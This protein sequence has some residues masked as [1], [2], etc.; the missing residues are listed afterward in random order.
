MIATREKMV[1]THRHIQHRIRE[2]AV[3]VDD[4][5]GAIEKTLLRLG[6]P[7]IHE[8]SMLIKLSPLIVE[9]MR[10]LVANDLSDCAIV[11]VLG[12]Q[13]GQELTLQNASG[14]LYA[15]Q[16]RKAVSTRLCATSSMPNTHVYYSQW[17]NKMH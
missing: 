6:F 5:F 1:V 10:D 8:V 9:S 12:T 16:R 2:I 14:E 15:N 3:L 13:G 11:Q 7:P 17:P 4:A